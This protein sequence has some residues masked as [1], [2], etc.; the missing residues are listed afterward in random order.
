MQ[1]Y[2]TSEQYQAVEWN[3]TA[4]YNGTSNSTIITPDMLRYSPDSSDIQS[5]LVTIVLD[6]E[7]QAEKF[8]VS[9]FIISSFVAVVAGF[10]GLRFGNQR[11]KR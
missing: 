9:T 2:T 8:P 10:F 1:Y 5:D 3:V 6:T 4:T 7:T 11:R